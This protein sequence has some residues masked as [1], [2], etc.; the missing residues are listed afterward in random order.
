[1]QKWKEQS[2]LF[3]FCYEQLDFWSPLVSEL[4]YDYIFF[5]KSWCDD[6]D[7]DVAGAM[8]CRVFS[9]SCWYCLFWTLANV[10][11][12]LFEMDPAMF[13]ISTH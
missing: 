13:V 7:N 6:D 1:M 3:S 8:M 10:K 11:C 2:H 9:N 12:L 5:A 4:K